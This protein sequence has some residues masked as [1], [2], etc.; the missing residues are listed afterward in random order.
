MAAFLTISKMTAWRTSD[1]VQ[2]VTKEEADR[3]VLSDQMIE[4]LISS[5]VAS[6]GTAQEAVRVF[7]GD[8]HL[9]RAW[10]DACDAC[11]GNRG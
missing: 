5:G 6:A 4:L 3:H 11:D 8:R 9:V 10:L 1:G 7:H 2:H